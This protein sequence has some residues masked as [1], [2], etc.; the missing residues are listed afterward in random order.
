MKSKEVNQM[1]KIVVLICL[2][3][4]LFGCASRELTPQ[5]R[6]DRGMGL[7]RTGQSEV[8]AEEVGD[9][10]LLMLDMILL[11]TGNADSTG[12]KLPR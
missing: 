7:Q 10:M 12:T 3:G 6:M 4:L 1:K 8:T 9:N 11:G 2:V 5:E